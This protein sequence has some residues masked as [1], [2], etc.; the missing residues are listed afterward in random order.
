MKIKI[1]I[2][3]QMLSYLHNGP[4]LAEHFHGQSHPFCSHEQTSTKDDEVWK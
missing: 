4:K 1:K 2:K 3:M